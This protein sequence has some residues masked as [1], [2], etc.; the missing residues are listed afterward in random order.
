MARTT[1][2]ADEKAT[3]SILIAMHTALSRNIPELR[4]RFLADQTPEIRDGYWCEL[5][6][7]RELL[8]L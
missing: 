2:T 1:P 4:D 8:D 7:A 3:A 6:D 5:A